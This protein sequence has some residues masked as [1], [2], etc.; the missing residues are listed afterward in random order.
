MKQISFSTYKKS[1]VFIGWPLLKLYTTYH[2]DSS[3]Y[4]GYENTL[5]LHKTRAWYGILIT[6]M[7]LRS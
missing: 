6:F 1:K 4:R 3:K 5:R 7:V 2:L